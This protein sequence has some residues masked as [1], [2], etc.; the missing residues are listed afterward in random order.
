MAVTGGTLGLAVLQATGTNDTRYWIGVTGSGLA[1]NLSLT[2]SITAAV[3]N[4]SIAINQAGG[5]DSGGNAATALDWATAFP[6][7][8]NPRQPADPGRAPIAFTAEQLALSG[9]L[10][11]S[12]SSK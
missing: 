3:A 10:T 9:T 5:K 12:T 8:V 2:S 7:P 4:L 1:A 6:T 11:T